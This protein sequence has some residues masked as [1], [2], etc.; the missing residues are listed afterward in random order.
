M[1]RPT[2]EELHAWCIATA[3]S[4]PGTCHAESANLYRKTWKGLDKPRDKG[5]YHLYID[6]GYAQDHHAFYGSWDGDAEPVVIDNTISQFGGSEMVFIGTK[7][8]WMKQVGSLTGAKS[9]KEDDRGGTLYKKAFSAEQGD[10][11]ESSESPRPAYEMEQ[12][13]NAPKASKD[14]HVKKALHCTIL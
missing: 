8:E 2:N 5:I 1:T 4:K 9:V 14:V 6:R 12:S 7:A 3:S 13:R 11:S 10:S